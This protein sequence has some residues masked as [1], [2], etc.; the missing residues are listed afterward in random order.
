[1]TGLFRRRVQR[2]LKPF[3]TRAA[4]LAIAFARNNGIAGDN[5]DRASIEGVVNEVCGAIAF[6]QPVEIL[7]RHAH[8]GAVIVIAW[9]GVERRIQILQNL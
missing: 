6:W 4:K 5:A 8:V 3:E 2:R 7:E 9:N 1:M